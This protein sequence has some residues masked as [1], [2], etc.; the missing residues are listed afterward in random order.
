MFSDV[1]HR[2]LEGSQSSFPYLCTISSVR[3]GQVYKEIINNIIYKS[4]QLRNPLGTVQFHYIHPSISTSC[5]AITIS[6][7]HVQISPRRLWRN[8]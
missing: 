4:T 7:E 1:M 2:L 3:Q 6:K 8:G 5:V